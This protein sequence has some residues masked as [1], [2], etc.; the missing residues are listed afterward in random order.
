MNGTNNMYDTYYVVLSN[1]Y[2]YDYHYHQFC[3]NY[4]IFLAA[5]STTVIIFTSISE[6]SVNV[7]LRPVHMLFCTLIEKK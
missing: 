3:H 5:Y 1:V 2:I 7:L 4:D 6:C